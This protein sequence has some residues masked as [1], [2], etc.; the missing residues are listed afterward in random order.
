MWVRDESFGGG[1][2]F[3]KKGVGTRRSTT[4]QRLRRQISLDYYIVP[5]ATQTSYLEVHF[6]LIKY[7]QDSKSQTLRMHYPFQSTGTF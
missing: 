2:V 7:T 3:Q 4:L 6:M 1:A 5:P